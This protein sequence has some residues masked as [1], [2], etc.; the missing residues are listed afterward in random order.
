M[1]DMGALALGMI[2]TLAAVWLVRRYAH[3]ASQ[4]AEEYAHRTPLLDLRRHLSGR[5]RCDGMIFGP[6][7]RMTSR[8][9]AVMSTTWDGPRGTM[10]EHFVY[11]DGTTQDRQWRLT[12]RDDG[13]VLAEADDVEGA[14]EGR[15]GGNA[16]G[17]RYRIRLPDTSGG[18]VLDAVDWMYLQEDGTILNRSQ[19]TKFGIKV[20]ELFAT[21]RPIAE[22]GRHD[23]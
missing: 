5:S 17:M 19:F 2:L 13:S 15:L 14:G 23:A 10:D 1:N 7:G 3:F 9:N 11:D 22:G 20:A 8:F 18:H 21:I 16:Y 6:T 4:R 12:L